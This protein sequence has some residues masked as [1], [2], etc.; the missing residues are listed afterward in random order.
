MPH[1]YQDLQD[2]PSVSEKEAVKGV[3][4]NLLFINHSYPELTEKEFKSHK[5]I[6]EAEFSLRL[7]YYFLQQNYKAEQITI[8]CTYLDQ[9][10]DIRKKAY[11]RFGKDHGFV[12][13][14][15]DNYQGEENDIVILSLVRSNNPENKIGFLKIP[16]RVCVALSRAKLGLYVIGNIDFLAKNCVLWN[17]IRKSAQDAGALSNELIVSCQMHQN[18]QIIRDPSDFET[19]CREGGCDVPCNGRLE[20]GHQCI[21]P[22][23]VEDMN[24]TIQKCLKRC[25]R[26]CKSEFQHPCVKGC[27]EPCGDCNVKVQKILPC[28]HQK[29]DYCYLDPINVQCIEDC[30]KILSCGHPCKERCGGE[31]TR[32]CKEIVERQLPECGHIVSMKCGDNI[33]PVKCNA[34]VTKIWPLCKHSVETFCSSNVTALPCPYPCNMVLPDCEHLCKG[35]CGKCRNGRLHIPCSESC[36]K[37]FLC[38][39][40]CETKCSKICPPCSK[41]CET[42]CGHSQCGNQSIKGEQKKKTRKLYNQKKGQQNGRRCG[43]P[44]P[45]C[46]EDCLNQ[47]KHR[48]CSKKCGDPCD[49]EPCFE[50]CTKLLPCNPCKQ[51]FKIFKQTDFGKTKEVEWLEKKLIEAHPNVLT[52]DWFSTSRNILRIIQTLTKYENRAKENIEAFD[53]RLMRYEETGMFKKIDVVKVDNIKNMPNFKEKLFQLQI[54]NFWGYLKDECNYLVARIHPFEI[55]QPMIQQITYEIQRFGFIVDLFAYFSKAIKQTIDFTQDEIEMISEIFENMN[56]VGSDVTH[57]Y[58]CPNGHTYGIGDCGGVVMKTKCPECKEEIGGQF[59]RILGSNQDA[60]AE[61]FEGTEINAN[62]YQNPFEV[63]W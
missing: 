55:S 21:K 36:N 25:E 18:E 48:Q 29:I 16:N 39:H 30:Q 33:T 7:A 46:M 37:I 19:K 11:E 20:C 3:T 10:L 31:C 35:T 52:K 63:R 26:K 13:Q 2:D 41:P 6:F 42:E 57:W 58:K 12:I 28:N 38:E 56:A 4:K 43:E 23:H 27:W 40:K 61:M 9:L 15:V 1:F 60:Q 62:P 44:C 49:V 17:E 14:S 59:H 22:C 47:C 32:F 34:A 51:V 50:P 53:Q 45:P 54:T 24:H 8:L 5:N